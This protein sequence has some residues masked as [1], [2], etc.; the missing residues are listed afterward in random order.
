MVRIGGGSSFVVSRESREVMLRSSDF[1]PVSPTARALDP[2]AVA[3]ILF[4]A[5]LVN[6]QPGSQGRLVVHRLAIGRAE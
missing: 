2:T 5:D 1:V 6:F 3:S 4:V